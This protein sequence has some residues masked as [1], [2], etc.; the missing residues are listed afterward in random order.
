MLYRLTVSLVL[1]WL[2]TGPGK[3]CRGEPFHRSIIFDKVPISLDAP[4][5][6]EATIVDWSEVANPAT[7]PGWFVMNARIDKIIKGPI[8]RGTLKIVTEA[9]DCTTGFGVGSRGIVLGTLRQDPQGGVELVAIQE[10][11]IERHVRE[12]RE[13]HK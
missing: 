5:V 3:A 12:D 9:W 10:S 6:V 8:D 11:N 13:K 2:A 1:V 7:G 4:V